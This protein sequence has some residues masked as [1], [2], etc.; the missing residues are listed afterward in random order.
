MNLLESAL[1]ADTLDA[2]L[3]PIQQAL[4]ITTGDCAAVVFSGLPRGVDEWP[5]LS[6]EARR[7]WLAQW[8]ATELLDAAQG[9]MERP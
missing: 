7:D 9:V 5:N 2:S 3:A 6:L 1:R 8:L 4:G